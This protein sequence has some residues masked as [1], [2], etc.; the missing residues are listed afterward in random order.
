MMTKGARKTGEKEES[1]EEALRRLEEI[2]QRLEGGDL[3]LEESLRVFEEGVRLARVCSQQLDLAERRIDI[4]MRDQRGEVM[5]VQG[6]PDS[7]GKKGGED[8]GEG[9][10]G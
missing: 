1:F 6:D 7:F 4:L 3:S 10:A 2:V 8:E 5:A 9:Q